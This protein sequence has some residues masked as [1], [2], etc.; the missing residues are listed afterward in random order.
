METFNENLQSK[1]SSV[2]NEQPKES[3]AQND[4]APY[5]Y[6]FSKNKSPEPVH[7]A[8]PEH[9]TL[10]HQ[11]SW[12]IN[13]MED[14][15]GGVV[16]NGTELEPDKRAHPEKG[17]I[18]DPVASTDDN[19]S[20]LQHTP[21]GMPLSEMPSR[22]TSPPISSNS[23]NP[24]KHSELQC[25]CLEMILPFPENG[26]VASQEPGYGT[27]KLA[28]GN[29]VLVNYEQLLQNE[30]TKRILLQR[31]IDTFER[32]IE[33]LD[34]RNDASKKLAKE[35]ED[36][37]REA[38]SQLVSARDE[39]AQLKDVVARLQRHMDAE[40]KRAPGSEARLFEEELA[41]SK[42]QKEELRMEVESLKRE[43][44]RKNDLC[45]KFEASQKSLELALEEIRDEKR[46]L[47]SD[48]SESQAT[49]EKL[50]DTCE[51]LQAQCDCLN[52]KVQELVG[53]NSGSKDAEVVAA[54]L[55]STVESLENDVSD[56]T[57]EID[58]LK[59]QLGHSES[60]QS[61]VTAERN[62][63]QRECTRLESEISEMKS[64]LVSLQEEKEVIRSIT[65]Y[66]AQIFELN[67]T[68]E[69][70]GDEAV[71]KD[72]LATEVASLQYELGMKTTE[73]EEAA[74]SLKLL[75]TKLDCAEARISESSATPSSETISNVTEPLKAEIELLEKKLSNS[76]KAL[77]DA[78]TFKAELQRKLEDSR[79]TAVGL[80]TEVKSLEAE[81]NEVSTLREELNTVKK[82]L[83]DT[84]VKFNELTFS[85]DQLEVD[86]SEHE[87]HV[88]SLQSTISDLDKQVFSLREE[89]AE[90][91]TT[92]EDN[93]RKYKEE[94]STMTKRYVILAEEEQKLK[95]ELDDLKVQY[96]E[97][98]TTTSETISKYEQQVLE[99]QG[100]NLEISAALEVVRKNATNSE[101]LLETKEKLH[102]EQSRSKDLLSAIEIATREKDALF[103]KIDDLRQELESVSREKTHIAQTLEARAS[104]AEHRNNLLNIESATLQK[105]NA[106]ST[107]TIAKL[108]KELLVLK[109]ANAKLE[110]KLFDMSFD[111]DQSSALAE[112]NLK[113]RNERDQ[114]KNEAASLME[115][116]NFLSSQMKS[117]AAETTDTFSADERDSLL[118][119]ISE[120]EEALNNDNLNDLRD[121]LTSLHEER[122]ELDA[123][124]EELLVQLG[125]MQQN[126]EDMQAELSEMREQVELL[127]TQCKRLQLDL[128]ESRKAIKSSDD[129]TDGGSGMEE[130]RNENAKLCSEIVQLNDERT[131]LKNSI[132]ELQRQLE[133]FKQK[134]NQ[135]DEVIKG[136]IETD[137]LREKLDNLELQ[138][139]KRGKELAS[140]KEE[141]QTKLDVK[142]KIISEL[143][144][145][146]C[147]LE[148]N[149]KDISKNEELKNAELDSLHQ[150]VET[151][152]IENEQVANPNLGA[153]VA[154][155]EKEFND[156]GDIQD[157]LAEDVDSDDY[158]RRQIVVLALA[159]ER[160]EM[161]RADAIERVVKERKSNAESLKQLG[162]SV[163]RFYN[164][165][166]CSDAL[167]FL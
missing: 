146:K 110:S 79:T 95:M 75:Q 26:S 66:K 15:K 134:S 116:I 145:E 20:S 28:D 123:D 102:Q 107:Q 126:E 90:L 83:E 96:N 91:Q 43:L 86:R 2:Q 62:K 135:D 7:G 5:D 128:D 6:E 105:A 65:K 10:T 27:K 133:N 149:I 122:Q 106:E 8:L 77:A 81:V 63:F 147:S 60:N 129:S 54:Q 119:R 167:S 12:Y 76:A 132:D 73:C 127:E 13:A 57:R 93:K 124:N 29:I 152:R 22:S 99:L 125:L 67:A 161:Q 109:D 32:T 120:L 163:K 35:Q 121:E 98:S 159:L 117:S 158:L 16:Y 71:E 68:I 74:E 148:N 80:E 153:D 55:Q 130:L 4:E 50:R 33:K 52:V 101:E 39:I 53:A 44:E 46:Q 23:E 138:L 104:A 162:E 69:S 165:V 64:N 157:L 151:L 56:K 70:M 114:L 1:K 82:L 11:Q 24:F 103:K 144:S 140:M 156:V 143:S 97:L 111:A 84:R 19:E 112:E 17:H 58:D 36:A 136:N 88:S 18:I 131:S 48:L 137:H 41:A 37:K 89:Y 61:D 21:V 25:Q 118:S 9:P 164:A 31:S 154:E 141:F 100:E 94:H 87:E 51:S 166:R 42:T 92:F 139:A 113:L 78:E 108:N 115:K 30:A 85:R 72:K 38:D 40:K 160:S 47:Q 34:A 142:D 49:A 45:N 3:P 59:R 14:G 155:E 150:Q